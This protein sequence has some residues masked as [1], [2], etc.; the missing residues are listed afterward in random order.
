[1]AYIKRKRFIEEHHDFYEYDDEP[2]KRGSLLGKVAKGALVLGS[3]AAATKYGAKRYAKHQ[4]RRAKAARSAAYDREQAPINATANQRKFFDDRNKQLKKNLLTQADKI[5]SGRRTKLA[6]KIGGFG[7]KQIKDATG[8]IGNKIN[9]YR[10]YFAHD[11]NKFQAEQA[12]RRATEMQRRVSA[13]H[14]NQQRQL[15]NQEKLS[16]KMR[17]EAMLR[18]R[19]RRL[20]NPEGT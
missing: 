7:D 3:A 12:E 2:R 16:K 18:E 4:E 17:K 20:G 19:Y 11:H 9:A 8:K 14:R 6:Q 5:E 13:A 15:E 10:A 1:M